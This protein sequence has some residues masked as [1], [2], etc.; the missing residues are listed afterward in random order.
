MGEVNRHVSTENYVKTAIKVEFVRPLH[1]GG[2]GGGADGG[3]GGVPLHPVHFIG[4]S[5][6]MYLT[7][8]SHIRKDGIISLNAYVGNLK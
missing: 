4:L 6:C 7:S 2:T 5:M 3:G 1:L 8:Y